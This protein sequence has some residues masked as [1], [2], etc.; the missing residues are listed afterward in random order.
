MIGALIIDK[1]EGFTSH[2]IVARVRRA[3]GTKRVGHAGTLDPFATG[4][5]VCCIGPATRLVQFLV[6][7]DKEYI[8]TVRLGYATDTQDITGKRITSLQSASNLSLDELQQTLHKFVG[9]Q[10]QIPPMFSAKKVGGERLYRAAREGREV[11]RNPVSI[12]VHSMN[13]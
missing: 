7:V 11:E 12:I 8:A 3:A 13:L 1:P 9:P 4:A 5:L 2:D 10:W 6:G